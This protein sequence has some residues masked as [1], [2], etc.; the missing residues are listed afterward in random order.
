MARHR[1]DRHCV[2]DLFVF[3]VVCELGKQK[4]FNWVQFFYTIDITMF[5]KV[6]LTPVEVGKGCKFYDTGSPETLFFKSDKFF[7]ESMMRAIYG[8]MCKYQIY[9]F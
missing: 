4:K 3:Q 1:V 7:I 6:M 2:K 9:L 8:P 5:R